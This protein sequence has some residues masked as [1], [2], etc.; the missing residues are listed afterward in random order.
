MEY[1]LASKNDISN[2]AKLHVL[3]WQRN[4]RGSF[5][6]RYLDHEIYEDRLNV[7]KERLN[8]PTDTQHV[9]LAE[10]HGKVM[11]FVCTF[12]DYH[13]DWGAYLDNLHVQPNLYGKGIGAELLRK[14]AGYVRTHRPDSPLFLWVLEKN[15]RGIRFYERMGGVNKGVSNFDNPGGGTSNTI[16]I[17][18]EEPSEL[19]S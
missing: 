14:S 9:L 4:Y 11:G 17:V 6:D 10:D 1:R 7:W 15:K 8:N 13:K 18:W 12:L 16:R 2:I 3:S 19:I 5:Q